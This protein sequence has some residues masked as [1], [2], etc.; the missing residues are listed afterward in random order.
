MQQAY[1]HAARLQLAPGSDPSAPGAAVTVALCGHWQHDGPCRW[2]HHTAVADV[3]GA[4]EVR[5]V[6]VSDAVD[7]PGVRA[8]IDDA[9]ESGEQDGPDG[10]VSTWIML[11]SAAD[12]LRPDEQELAHRIRATAG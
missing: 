10:L 5:T 2:P 9:L 12:D 7:E 6:V 11:S 8:R 4:L 3:E 1:V